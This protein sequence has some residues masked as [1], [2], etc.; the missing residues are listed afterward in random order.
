MAGLFGLSM[1]SCGN[2]FFREKLFWG[3][4]YNRHLGEM[5]CGLA[6][7]DASGI[8]VSETMPGS[9]QTNFKSK[10]KKFNGSEAISY[11]GSAEEPFHVKRS[12]FGPF[13]VCFN[14]NIIN[15][16][17]IVREFEVDDGHLFE[18]WN[19]VEIIAKLLVKGSDFMQGIEKI[20]KRIEGAYSFL[21]LS[22]EGVIVTRCD[23]GRWPLVIGKHRK[24][25]AVIVSSECVGF[26]NLEF[27]IV[28]NVKPGETILLKNGDWNKVESHKCKE[29]ACSFYGVY[30]SS[31]GAIVHGIPAA[32][33]REK[34]GACF[35]KR[36]IADGLNPHIILPV[37]DSGRSH[38]IGYKQEFDNEVNRQIASGKVTLKRV[39]Y[40]H[41]D[42]IK[43]GFV[44]SFLGLTPKER[45]ERAHYKII[46][47][48]KTIVN[49][50]DMLKKE[51]LS[52]IA[53]DILENQCIEIVI[54]EDSV[55]RGT[56]V[57]GNLVPKLRFIYER[58]VSEK[59]IK[60]KIYVRASYPEILSYCPFGATTKRGEV[61][62]ELHPKISERIKYLGV[63]G[64][65]YNTI[66]DLVRVLNT[67]R[68]N[69]CMS[70]AMIE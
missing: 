62:T 19:D 37:P 58:R 59:K 36:D 49:F 41:E 5:H 39:P 69:L 16:D 18:T 56:Q 70:C 32:E 6:S 33:I 20:R 11:C 14:G 66:E 22:Q 51:N 63:D 45:E 64:L 1:G 34:L 38:A 13:V 27:D 50:I 46:I 26:Y 7:I 29:K 55:V 9:F 42:L 67:S 30:T 35:A 3:T 12:K 8:I 65:S 54:C 47:T 24:Y 48:G 60:V 53:N 52:N 43:Y 21:V 15:R 10:M 4:S 40:Y 44:R 28:R 57:R 31:P 23:A 68:E 25:S 61:L 17:Q 2:A